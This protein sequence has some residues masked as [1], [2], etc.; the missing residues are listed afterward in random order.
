MC[1][2][3]GILK[4]YK[5]FYGELQALPERKLTLRLIYSR[6][7]RIIHRSVR[8]PL[9]KESPEYD[10]KLHLMVMQQFWISEEYRVFL[11]C[12]Y[13]LV[14]PVGYRIHRLHLYSEVTPS[15]SVLD[16]TLNNLIMRSQWCWSF[17]KCTPS[18]PSLSGPLW[19]GI[20]A[21]DRV[22]SMG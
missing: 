12:F 11:H 3:S 15:T 21:P 8:S 14:C 20:I 4:R 5:P 16:M 19:P 7:F 10:T 2:Y 22:L 18:L 9:S 6:C 17:G 1:V 13:S